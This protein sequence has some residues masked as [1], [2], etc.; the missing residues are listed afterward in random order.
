MV[1]AAVIV[2]IF[3]IWIGR[4]AWGKPNAGA[5]LAALLGLIIGLWFVFAAASPAGAGLLALDA[6]K[7]VVAFASGLG[8][9]LRML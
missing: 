4:A 5:R 8:R 2:V 6:G 1:A 9:F 3:A 7:G